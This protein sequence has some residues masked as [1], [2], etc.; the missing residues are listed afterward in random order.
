[1]AINT[2]AISSRTLPFDRQTTANGSYTL[3][4]YAFIPH[5][6]LQQLASGQVGAPLPIGFP[7]ASFAA[8][9]SLQRAYPVPDLAGVFGF[10]QMQVKTSPAS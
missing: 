2:V 8:P 9:P 4:R 3:P 6:A 7:A 1:M 5:P 10:R